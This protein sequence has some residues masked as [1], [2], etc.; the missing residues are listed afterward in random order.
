[1]QTVA[2]RRASRRFNMNLPLVVRFAAGD[3]CVEHRGATRDVS[4][5]G[6]YFMVDDRPEADASVE[7]VLTLPNE[8]TLGADFH[9]RCHGRVVRLERNNGR[10]GVAARIDRY[11]IVN[12]P[13]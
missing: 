4:F 8:S 11:E 2:E 13:A 3:R 7:F 9:V 1:M 6:L 5:R 12:S 10:C